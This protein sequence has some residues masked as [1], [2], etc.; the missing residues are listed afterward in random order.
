MEV[1][2][3][4]VY[5]TEMGVAFGEYGVPTTTLRDCISEQ[6]THGTPMRARSYLNQHEEDTLEEFLLTASS[7]GFGKTRAPVMMSA[8]M[9]A[10]GR[11]F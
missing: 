6:V 2:M 9:V 3:R 1:A 11:I 4:A 10:R 7:I 5:D 8:E